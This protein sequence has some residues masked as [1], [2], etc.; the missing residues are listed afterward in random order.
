MQTIYISQFTQ[1]SRACSSYRDFL[2]R[3]LL[4]T[5]N[6]TINI[7]ITDLLPLKMNENDN[8]DLLMPVSDKRN[9]TGT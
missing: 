2:E 3:D 9:T 4:Q 1:Y 6:K 8:S 5:K 7:T